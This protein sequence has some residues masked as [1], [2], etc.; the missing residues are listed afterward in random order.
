MHAS[1]SDPIGRRIC[2]LLAFAAGIAAPANGDEPRSVLAIVGVHVVP[3]DA[4]RVLEDHTVIVTEGRITAL[5]PAEEV[6]VPDDARVVAGHGRYLMPGLADMHVHL[7]RG[8]DEYLNYVRH[9]VTAV[10][11]LGGSEAHGARIL[12]DRRQIDA[13]EMLGPN[14]YATQRIF[15]GDPPLATN[16]YRLTT[17]EAARRRTAELKVAGFD[18]IKVYNNVSLPVYRAIL[19]EAARQDMAVVGH[20]PRGFDPLIALEGHKAVVHTEEFFFTYFRGP[21][22]TEDMDRGYRPDL[23]LIPRLLEVLLEG[24]VAVIPNLSFVFTNFLMWDGLDN[25]WMN[26]ELRFQHPATVGAWRAG[27][28]NRRKEIENFIFREQ[29][30]AGLM[31]ELTRRF[32][33][34]GVLQLLGTDSALPG[35]FPGESAHRELTELVK[36]GLSNWDALSIGTRNAGEFVH[37]HIDDEERFG[38]IEPGYRAD[39][40]LVEG[41]PLEDVRHARRITAV[42]VRGRWIER[43]E[44]DRRRSALADR[45]QILYDLSEQVDAAL[46]QEDAAAVV[47]EILA[48]HGKDLEVASTIE[49]RL[50]SA[51]YG[52]AMGGDLK[53]A[54]FILRLATELFPESANT[55]DSLAELNLYQENRD[56][57]IEYY[58]KALEVDP[59]FTNAAQQLQKLLEE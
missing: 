14:I 24:D 9:G 15:D 46:G 10:M 39:L 7:R 59:G 13:G 31:Q 3:M 17:P 25:V 57:A 49:D 8:S 52:A 12:E 2:L 21:R 48:A 22:S 16:S 5:G 1:P 37:E 18:F 23:S 28:I 51:G 55:W 38:R 43:S 36:A 56:A 20:I 47:A 35:L 11:H 40:L 34:A 27:N 44:L 30:K 32:Q 29:I 6:V 33:Q 4:P 19:A 42:A 45:Y 26:P 41:D 53:R 54:A 58:R 50:N